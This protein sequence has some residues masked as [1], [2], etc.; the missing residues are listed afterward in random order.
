MGCLSKETIQYKAAYKK[1]T[2]WYV[3]FFFAVKDRDYLGK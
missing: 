1:G 2:V 3:P